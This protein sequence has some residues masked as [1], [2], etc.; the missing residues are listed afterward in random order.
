[1]ILCIPKGSME[2]VILR[3]VLQ[4]LDM[5]YLTKP[6]EEMKLKFPKTE[7]SEALTLTGF[8]AIFTALT[9]MAHLLPSKA[10]DTGIVTEYLEKASHISLEEL[11]A[12]LES[13]LVEKRKWF[14]PHFTE[15][16]SAD[17]F[18]IY[19]LRYEESTLGIVYDEYPQ[20]KRYVA[21]DP[22]K[23]YDDDEETSEQESKGCILS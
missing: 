2:Y 19:R 16:T 9:R 17:F 23:E 5:P 10:V 14:V 3:A 13:N 20:I 4:Y 7:E 18:L 21:Q 12:A 15:S 11:E 6:D 8:R 1:M 22:S